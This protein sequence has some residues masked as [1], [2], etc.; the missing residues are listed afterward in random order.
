[1]KAGVEIEYIENDIT[2]MDNTKQ[3]SFQALPYSMQKFQKIEKNT[4][5]RIKNQPGM[6]LWREHHS[7]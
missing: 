4:H 3:S 6:S 1:M 2:C 7:L 5:T